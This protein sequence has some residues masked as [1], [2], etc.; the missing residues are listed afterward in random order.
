MNVMKNDYEARFSQLEAH[1]YNLTSYSNGEPPNTSNMPH[2]MIDPSQH[3]IY[4]YDE[5]YQAYDPPSS[6]DGTDVAVPIQ[7]TGNECDPLPPV[8]PERGVSSASIL[9]FNVDDLTD[10]SFDFLPALEETYFVNIMT[11]DSN[12]PHQRPPNQAALTRQIS[13]GINYYPPLGEPM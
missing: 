2:I 12:N 8:K 6:G 13:R 10:P 3:P 4:R 11:E 7:G 9:K 1:I 5:M